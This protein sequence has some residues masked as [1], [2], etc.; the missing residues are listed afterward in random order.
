MT[1]IFHYT[2]ADLT[3]PNLCDMSIFQPLVRYEFCKETVFSSLLGVLLV[4]H[5][6]TSEGLALVPAG[7]L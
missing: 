1:R 5:N 6:D 4:G 7:F 2:Q 3:I